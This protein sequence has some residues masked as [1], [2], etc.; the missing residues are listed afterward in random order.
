M[1]KNSNRKDTQLNVEAFL[2]YV[3]SVGQHVF[4]VV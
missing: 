3:L 4:D 2:E 1:K